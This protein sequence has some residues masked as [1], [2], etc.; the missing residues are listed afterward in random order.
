MQSK[1]ALPP[2]SEAWELLCE[3]TLNPQLRKHALGVEA[4]MRHFARRA[5]EDEDLWGLVGLLHDFDYERYPAPPDHPLKGAEVLAQRRYPETL[6]RAIKCHAPYLGLS[7]DTPIERTIF[8]VDEITGFVV[9]VALVRPQ[10]LDGLEPRSV[11]KKFKDRA[12][13]RGVNRD[14]V[15]LGAEELG[16]ALP[17]L[18]T[19]VRDALQAAEAELRSRGETLLAG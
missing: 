10:G 18:I 14:D 1:S 7:R 12:F 2:R 3:Y 15:L 8:A 5:G 19:E 6:I 17:D 9:A 4:V 16:L 13:A 11:M